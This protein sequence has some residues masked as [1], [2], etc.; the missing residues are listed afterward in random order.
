MLN[1]N[2]I[3][4]GVV[5]VAMIGGIIF[6]SSR[7]SSSVPD[8][9]VLEKGVKNLT[10][11][12][13]AKMIETFLKVN[14]RGNF[15]LLFGG[16]TK[17]YNYD[18]KLG[19]YNLGG[20]SATDSSVDIQTIRKLEEAGFVKIIESKKNPYGG[21]YDYFT[22]DFT[23]QADP[24]LVKQGEV[25]PDN[26]NVDVLLAELVSVEVTGLT[27]Q[28]VNNGVNT[29]IANF[30]ATYKA[31]PIGAIIDEKTAGAEFKSLMPFTLYD[32]GWRIIGG[33][34]FGQ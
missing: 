14:P 6:F 7:N 3:I 33:M 31:T 21:F 28:A 25:S 13:A 15:S 29:R 22:F 4:I 19:H 9:S 32:D 27:E 1:K 17:S 2:Y 8:A 24:Y 18:Q 23:D 11:E 5:I 20:Y 12:S 26:K 30:T 34:G 10:R 16:K